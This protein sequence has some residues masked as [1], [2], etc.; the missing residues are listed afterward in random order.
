M[1]G[2]NK[3][4]C[5]GVGFYLNDPHFEIK[6]SISEK[7]ETNL[8]QEVVESFLKKIKRTY[9]LERCYRVEF[10]KDV[11]SHIGLG[12][13]TQIKYALAQAVLKLEAIDDSVCE[14]AHKLHLSGVSGIGYGAFAEGGFVM[15]LGYIF[16]KDK[17]NFVEHSLRPP[18]M[19]W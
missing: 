18:T 4:C 3:R 16:G 10:L 13:E 1:N 11:R 19:P 6:V 5:G 9:N 7:D 15:D 2:F 8:H 12:S 14:F 17:Q